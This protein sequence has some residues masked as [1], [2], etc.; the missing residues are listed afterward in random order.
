MVKFQTS[1]MN[2]LVCSF[3]QN[4]NP[5][6]FE[7]QTKVALCGTNCQRS[8]RL[9]Q[10]RKK[11]NLSTKNTN[12]TSG[13][14]VFGEDVE[15]PISQVICGQLRVGKNWNQVLSGV[16]C[17]EIGSRISQSLIR[18]A[19]TRIFADPTQ[20]ILEPVV[21]SLDAY[22]P[23]Q[24]TGKFGMGFF[25]L[26]YWVINN[27]AR[28]VIDSVYRLENG[29]LCGYQAII[30]HSGKDGN[31]LLL[32][33]I[34]KE[35]DWKQ[36]FTNIH[37]TFNVEQDVKE[38]FLR[39]LQKLEYISTCDIFVN[40]VL[41][42]TGSKNRPRV[43]VT[44]NNN[45][46][47]CHDTA[48]G[49]S[50]ETL[51]G[52]LLFPTVSTKT[53]QMASKPASTAYEMN[54]RIIPL[55]NSKKNTLMVLVNSIVVVKLEFATPIGEKFVLLIDLP[56][57]TKV[58]VSRDDVL[59]SSVEDVFVR[60]VAKITKLL[61]DTA[62]TIIPIEYGL[63]ALSNQ[64]ASSDNKS[65]IS[66]SF[67]KYR[68]PK[69]VKYIGAAHSTVYSCVSYLFPD[70]Q[71]VTS[72]EWDPDNIQRLIRE[73]EVK[74]D[75]RF[76]FDCSVIFFECPF[77]N[78]IATTGGLNKYIFVNLNVMLDDNWDVNLAAT[79]Y[80]TTLYPKKGEKPVNEIE[81]DYTIN[82]AN[83][84]IKE[85][86][87]IRTINALEQTCLRNGWVTKR[88]SDDL[89]IN[90]FILLCEMGLCNEDFLQIIIT[91]WFP[92][93]VQG[94]A[95]YEY[96]KKENY[97]SFDVRAYGSHFDTYIPEDVQDGMPSIS[98]S[99]HYV[100]DWPDES[101][102]PYFE[103][104][105]EYAFQIFRLC[106]S[107]NEAKKNKI[108]Y[109][110]LEQ[111]YMRCLF[112]VVDIMHNNF[113]PDL[114][115]TV[116]LKSTSVEQFYCCHRVLYV[117]AEREFQYQTDAWQF[118]Y[119]Q[120]G[121]DDDGEKNDI[122]EY[123]HEDDENNISQFLNGVNEK[124]RDIVADA[125]IKFVQESFQNEMQ[126][127]FY[128]ETYQ[129]F[130]I[131]RNGG[132]YVP[133]FGGEYNEPTV[134]CADAFV[135]WLRDFL[136]TPMD[137]EMNETV[138]GVDKTLDFKY[139]KRTPSFTLNQLV[140]YT[141]KHNL[142]SNPPEFMQ[143]MR[144]TGNIGL[145][146]IKTQ[147]IEIVVN[148][149][150]TK[151]PI[152]AQLTETA[153]NSLDAIKEYQPMNC[154]IDISVLRT[155]DGVVISIKDYVGISTS[156]IIAI[157]IPFYSTKTNN[158][159]LTGE[160]G[161]GFFNVYRSNRVMIE[162]SRNGVAYRIMDSPVSDPDTKRVLDVER[163]IVMENNKRIDNKTEITIS[164]D[165]TSRKSYHELYIEDSVAQSFVKN[166]LALMMIP[167]GGVVRLNGKIVSFSLVLKKRTDQFEFYVSD[168]SNKNKFQSQLQTKGVP[169]APL[170]R[171][172][173]LMNIVNPKALEFLNS[174]CVIN[175]TSGI[176]TPVQTRTKISLARNVEYALSTFIED[177]AFE[178]IIFSP[179]KTISKYIEFYQNGKR[180]KNKMLSLFG[181]GEQLV[182][183]NQVLPG[184]YGD[185]DKSFV[186]YYVHS[187][188]NENIVD[189]LHRI[190]RLYK[191]A[192]VFENN[193][194][195]VRMLEY[196]Q[197]PSNPIHARMIE[198]CI[199]WLD[200]KM[201][202][203]E[204][205]PEAEEIRR[206]TKPRA[207]P[208]KK[209][210]EEKKPDPKLEKVLDFLIL[211]VNTYVQIGKQL[212]IFS[213]NRN[214][215]SVGLST[216]PPSFFRPLTQELTFFIDQITINTH[217][218][219]VN[220]FESNNLQA[221][222]LK[223]AEMEK[224]N[225]VWKDFYSPN[226]TIAH[227]LEHFRRDNE[228]GGAHSEILADLPVGGQKVR[229]F[230][231]CQSDTMKSILNNG[232]YSTLVAKGKK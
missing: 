15:I 182:D 5:K 118:E 17:T 21:N 183:V 173:G 83:I 144:E 117:L 106:V 89:K 81:F 222:V 41:L 203:P 88:G 51:L 210:E 18:V 121:D 11:P 79:F 168:P 68:L 189:V 76:F 185:T 16:E 229:H 147:M 213:A 62:N 92:A 70:V 42:N 136:K 90:D 167:N 224:T 57:Y 48:I 151:E 32:R 87:L 148:E 181:G 73:K 176:Y 93:F 104:G 200:G 101:G 207:L 66:E 22:F 219:I 113:E 188:T 179:F 214:I 44:L 156:G 131:D 39:Q 127:E 125:L 198:I 152:V 166:K 230:G 102:E 8:Y 195:Q 138:K 7:G 13:C 112:P 72:K 80:E 71:F 115:K 191:Q 65:I 53:I 9:I 86:S 6:F 165:F 134:T 67:N 142:S 36:P 114:M 3:C 143:M 98:E 34:D 211:W 77:E 149:G 228:H 212:E 103:K 137:I 227:E 46:I 128:Q 192:G 231:Q 120:V 162:T 218:E 63:E 201:I 164:R 19:S 161:T 10:G 82:S 225:L 133:V 132:C 105:M 85:K 175:L 43:D 119:D 60:D 58:P 20:S 172:V 100:R 205:P 216:M 14:D 96:E 122:E 52:S 206:T 50:R 130:W 30:F 155:E 154:D 184:K 223:V 47:I 116:L 111:V 84:S 163:K 25:S 194:S 110:D 159:L 94:P 95:N 146:D 180:K 28:V 141:F 91:Q 78:I 169:F 158:Q 145:A 56:A 49:I 26:M 232:F 220:L 37:V 221:V 38:G 35:D 190:V 1:E 135:N 170:S 215:A 157:S 107:K 97:K 178:Y 40:N 24:K 54:G 199:D 197:R 153:Q 45:G 177:C 202:A 193:F 126:I 217:I 59:L 12:Q 64:T 27:R 4:D 31:P 99:N 187:T 33:L 123:D 75:N 61:I 139:D 129:D 2:K 150:T 226:G 55:V 69:N 124:N 140:A 174:D 208:E 74:T 29:N 171:Y 186:M 108:R 209:K 109:L 23:E 204:R 196:V 160:M